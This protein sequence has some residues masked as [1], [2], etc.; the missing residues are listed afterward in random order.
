MILEIP[1][2]LVNVAIAATGVVVAAGGFAGA[3]VITGR[4]ISKFLIDMDTAFDAIAS[5]R[6]SGGR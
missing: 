5:R 6:I 4:G 3:A 1:D 2:V